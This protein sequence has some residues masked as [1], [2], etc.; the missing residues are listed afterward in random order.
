M[1]KTDIL[2]VVNELGISLT[3]IETVHPVNT[4][5]HTPYSFSSFGSVEEAVL[6]AKNEQIKVLGIND[7]YTV[8][9]YAEFFRITSHYAVYPI[10]SIEFT[11]LIGDF[12]KNGIR[13]N[14]PQ[15]PGRIYLC[16]KGLSYPISDLHFIQYLKTLQE[17]NNAHAM[18]MLEKANE[19]FVTHGIPIHLDYD[20][21]FRNYARDIIRERHI[22]RAVKDAVFGKAFS[23]DDRRNLF[24]KIFENVPFNSDLTDECALEN[25]IRNNLLKKDKP[26]F[27]PEESSAFYSLDDLCKNI[28]VAGG[29]PCY[30]AILA[31][32]REKYTEFE[33]D[34]ENMHRY[35]SSRNIGCVEL[36]AP[37]N[38]LDTLAE[39]VEFFHNRNYIILFGTEHNT[40]GK[41]L[42]RVHCK[43][44]QPI[45][46]ELLKKAYE[47]TCVIA[48]HQF[49][50]KKTGSGY[51][52]ADGVPRTE[53]IGDFI[54]LGNHLI[55]TFIKNI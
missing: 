4:H 42:L 43:N 51:L 55:N 5:I 48:A 2:S 18:N 14:D 54:K 23:D 29:I 36:I 9:G 26:A 38:T 33:R 7:F 8:A 39:F 24:G 52:D 31:D 21:V 45:P 16:G 28:R 47:G 53:S 41:A 22:A 44:N 34:F 1:N 12:Q 37:R 20:A 10:F 40:P 46:D 50:M 32:H 35:L 49:L 6:Q 30:P 19:H 27:V 17:R 13:V 11:G 25:E 3:D 15:N